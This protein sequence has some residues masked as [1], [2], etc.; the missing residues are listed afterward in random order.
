MKRHF[1]EV[2]HDLQPWSLRTVEDSA[3]QDGPQWFTPGEYWGKPSLTF[4]FDG[5]LLSHGG[6][7]TKLRTPNVLV[8]NSSAWSNGRP[9]S[10]FLIVPVPAPHCER[11]AEWD[12]FGLFLFRAQI[13]CWLWQLYVINFEQETVDKRF[14]DIPNLQQ[15]QGPKSPFVC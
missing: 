15:I 4:V 11:T 3:A 9:S 6:N 5:S 13:F 12:G 1:D 2:D 10:E 8:A 7:G 14:L